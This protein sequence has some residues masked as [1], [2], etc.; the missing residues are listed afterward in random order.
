MKTT[1]DTAWAKRSDLYKQGNDLRKQGYALRKQG[2][3]LRKQGDDLWISAV[4][5]VG[6]GRDRIQWD[7]PAEGDCTVAGLMVFFGELM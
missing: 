5:G 4:E 3:D 6:L 1:L 2:H 7:V